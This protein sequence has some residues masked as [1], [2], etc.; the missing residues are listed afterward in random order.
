M[1]PK[2]LSIIAIIT[3][4]LLILSKNEEL[5][6]SIKPQPD[7]IISKN[8]IYS[9]MSDVTIT[10]TDKSGKPVSIITTESLKYY[11]NADQTSLTKP[12]LQLL[13][14]NQQQLQMSA[15]SGELNGADLASFNN[16]VRI[17]IKQEDGNTIDMKTD[18]LHYDI[19]REQLYTDA[20]I[21]LDMK[22]GQLTSK[23][24]EVDVKTKVLKLTSEVRGYYEPTK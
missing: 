12:Q 21:E 8:D 17:A 9:F 3:I 7:E 15:Q 20:E 2:I 1:N 24:M 22:T 14:D 5:P 10:T 13:E 4:T 23:G 18:T 19:S 11:K 6:L 16:Q